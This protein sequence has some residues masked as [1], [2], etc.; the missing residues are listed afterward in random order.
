MD[1]IGGERLLLMGGR[2][3]MTSL[4]FE[5]LFIYNVVYYYILKFLLH[6]LSSAAAPTTSQT[7]S[8]KIKLRVLYRESCK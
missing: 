8:T 4:H 6:D 1:R 5:G 2:A 7:S 3:L